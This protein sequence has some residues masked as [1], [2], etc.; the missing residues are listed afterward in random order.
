MKTFQAWVATARIHDTPVGDF[1]RDAR[2]AS[3]LPEI[4]TR[5]Q[6]SAYLWSR[7]ACAECRELVPEIWRSYKRSR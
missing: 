6:L 2:R 7:Q 1:I 5:D 3:D 4:E